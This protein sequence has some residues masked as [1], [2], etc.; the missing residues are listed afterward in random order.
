VCAGLVQ[1][2]LGFPASKC[3]LAKEDHLDALGLQYRTLLPTRKF[4][5]FNKVSEPS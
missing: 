5:R 3:M 2:F 1:A 4:R